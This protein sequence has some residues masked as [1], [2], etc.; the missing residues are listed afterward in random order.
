MKLTF[1]DNACCI[2]EADGF[3]ILT[4]PWL[5]EGAFEGSWYHYPPIQ[6]CPE[7]VAD[8]DAVYISHLHPDHY[9]PKTLRALR[10]DLPIIVLDYDRNFLHRML[11]RDGFHNL[12][13]LKPEETKSLGPFQLT[14]Y[15][16]FSRDVFHEATIGNIYDS[17]LVFQWKDFSIFHGNDNNPTLEAAQALRQ[18]HGKFNLAQLKYNAASPYPACFMNLSEEKRLAEAERICARN[19]DHLVE[20]CRILEPEYV[21]PFAGSFILA[22]KQ[23]EKNRYLGTCSWDTAAA[24]VRKKIPG[25]NTLVMNEKQSF[26]LARKRLSPEAYTPIPWEERF[27]YLEK[28]LRT[29]RYPFEQDSPEKAAQDIQA[30]LVEARRNLWAAQKRYDYVPKHHVY[31]E[32]E[33]GFFHIDLSKSDPEFLGTNA[34]FHRPYLRCRMDSRLLRRI[35]SRQAHWNNAEIGCHIDFYREPDIYE[36]DLHVMLSFLHGPAVPSDSSGARI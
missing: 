32:L 16:P 9:D 6:V 11:E 34:P 1:I 31:I 17:A 23:H 19:L 15:P 25:Q 22:G 33:T 35:L 36:P 21:M 13:P 20:I 27:A 12:F 14:M 24:F 5:S 10:K 18:K 29:I 2:V 8:V 4:D 28:H 26:D 3:R 7:D 30:S